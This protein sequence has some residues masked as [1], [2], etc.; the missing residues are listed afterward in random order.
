MAIK[1]SPSSEWLAGRAFR[2][3]DSLAE[4]IQVLPV[5]IVVEALQASD[6]IAAVFLIITLKGLN[7]N[8]R[9]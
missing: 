7:V 6:G 1:L 9:G 2:V 8:N 3:V 4:I 5:V